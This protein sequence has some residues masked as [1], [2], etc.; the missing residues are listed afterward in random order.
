[1]DNLSE[2]A[3]LLCNASDN[4]RLTFDSGQISDDVSCG[5]SVS[6]PT[7]RFA[8]LVSNGVLADIR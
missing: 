6:F 1:M 5:W 2:P 4:F 7:D 8:E 3:P